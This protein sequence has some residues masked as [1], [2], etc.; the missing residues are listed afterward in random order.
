MITCLLCLAWQDVISPSQVTWQA[1]PQIPGLEVCWAVGEESEPGLYLIL[2]RMA[3]GTSIPPHTHPDARIT[4]VIEGSIE[5]R[6]DQPVTRTMVLQ[7]GESYVAPA[8]RFHAVVSPKGG[9]YKE[10]GMGPTAT[11]IPKPQP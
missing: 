2:V 9:I 5:V 11:A 10:T 1:I 8:H 4:T 6:F 3:P 7:A